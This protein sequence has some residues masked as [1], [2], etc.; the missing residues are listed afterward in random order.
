VLTLVAVDLDTPAG[1]VARADRKG[2]RQVLI[3][4]VDNTRDA[5]AGGL[6]V[7]VELPRGETPA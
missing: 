3:N 7:C 1:I 2:A 6:V 4:V 5:L